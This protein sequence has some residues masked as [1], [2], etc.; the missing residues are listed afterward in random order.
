MRGF[1]RHVVQFLKSVIS[2]LEDT[3][4]HYTINT[5]HAQASVHTVEN[6]CMTPTFKKNKVAHTSTTVTSVTSTD[7]TNISKMLLTTMKF[8]KLLHVVF[9]QFRRE[10]V[11]FGEAMLCDSSI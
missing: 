3:Y 8:W 2:P 6:Q 7:I 11:R 4:V 5:E 1:H 10:S 9:L